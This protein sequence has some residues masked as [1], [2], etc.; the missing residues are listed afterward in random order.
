MSVRIALLAA[1]ASAALSSAAAA[2]DQPVAPVYVDPAQAETQGVPESPAVECQG[3][4]C[5]EDVEQS[6]IEGSQES[7]PDA[8]VLKVD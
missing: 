8:E 1:L 6:E 2:E 5:L 4:N 3:E 7:A